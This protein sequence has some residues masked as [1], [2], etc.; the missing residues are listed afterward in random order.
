MERTKARADVAQAVR[1]FVAEQSIISHGDHLLV[2]VSGG[3]DSVALLLC[4]CE[5]AA[6]L[7]VK[8]TVAHL[9]HG[10]RGQAADEDAHFVAD[11]CGRL[12]IPVVT[13][14]VDVAARRKE[15]HESLQQA[16]RAERFRFFAAI[17]REQGQN[18]IALAHHQGDQVETILLNLIRGTGLQGLAGMKPLERGLFGLTLIRPLL[19]VDRVDILAFLAERGQGYREDYTNLDTKYRRNLVRH[20]VLPLLS[21]INSDVAG[22][23]LRVGDHARAADDYI[24]L[25][26]ASPWQESYRSLPYG[27]G[28]RADVLLACHRA[29]GARLLAWAYAKEREGEGDLETVH[30]EACRRLLNSQTGRRIHLPGHI[31]AL[32]TRD[33][34]VFYRE[35]REPDTPFELELT[36]PGEV[37]LPDGSTLTAEPVEHLP[38]GYP[39]PSAPQAYVA[40]LNHLLKVR[41]RRPGDTYIPLG[42]SGHKKLKRSMSEAEIPL[43]WRDRLPVVVADGRVVWVPGLRIAEEFRVPETRLGYVFKLTYLHG[44][45]NTCNN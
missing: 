41:N 22:A 25:Q 38:A 14:K 21:G 27:T 45:K 37:T 30:I 44:G 10:L 11:L 35:R 33:C 43:P 3:A 17:C 1:Q 6:P 13:G 26:A 4:L 23:L 39:P 18:K 29:L 20:E 9:N 5:L 34:L 28:L 8:L 36:L 12:A 2:G 16:A 19:S 15:S 40:G 31:T 32:R 7:A 24:S 42:A